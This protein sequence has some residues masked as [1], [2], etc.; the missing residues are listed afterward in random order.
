MLGS[1]TDGSATYKVYPFPVNS[2]NLNNGSPWSTS[3]FRF[4]APV[5]GYYYTSYAGIVG[6]GT[7]T[8]TAGYYSV[9]VNGAIAY[10]SYRDTISTWE[11][12]H[13]AV[14]LK[15]TAGDWLAWAMN[16]APG[17]A[18][19]YTGGAYRNNHNICTVWL[20]G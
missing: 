7:Q 12:Q 18:S 3:T 1:C 20:V 4:T 5:S 2:V 16:L 17:N 13:V 9:I 15:L 14:M 6:D 11:E 8:Q 19:T 10:F